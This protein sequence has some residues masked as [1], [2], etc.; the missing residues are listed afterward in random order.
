MEGISWNGSIIGNNELPRNKISKW[1]IKINNIAKYGYNSDNSWNLLIGIG[2]DN[3]NE[4]RNFQ[5]KC[6]SFICGESKIKN[7]N[8]EKDYIE[9][10]KIKNNDI[11]GVIVDR[12]K[13]NLSFE[14]NGINYGIA[15]SDIPKED[16]LYPVINICDNNQS[17]EILN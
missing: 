11:I 15:C 16:K 4:E 2:P 8:N 17:F 1:K 7:K 10:I 13:G 6:W 9:K 14:V 12:Q 3:I 5:R